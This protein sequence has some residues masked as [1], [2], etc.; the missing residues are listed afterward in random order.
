MSWEIS[1]LLGALISSTDAASVFSILRSKKLNL[2]YNTASL[3]EVESGSND[4]CA[5]MLT[6]AFIAISQGSASPGNIAILIVKQLAFGI[7][8]GVLIAK[9]SI[10]L[11]R[12]IRFK[13]AGFD[14]IFM[15]GIAIISMP[16]LLTLTETAS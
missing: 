1:F 5:Y 12:Y 3:L 7:I 15:V 6:V 14:A 8:F 4:P 9:L 13:S 16:C 11:L 2:K 10:M